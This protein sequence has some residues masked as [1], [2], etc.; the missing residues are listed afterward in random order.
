RE[1][2]DHTVQPSSLVQETFMRLFRGRD[3]GWRDRAHFFA[4]ASLRDA[5]RTG[6]PRARAT[7]QKTWK[8]GGSHSDRSGR[9]SVPG[10]SR[11]GG[12]YRPGTATA[13]GIGPSQEQSSGDAAFWRTEYGRKSGSSGNCIQHSASG[14]ELRSCL[15]PSRVEWR[16]VHAV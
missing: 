7:S 2:K 16:E 9:G 11:R 3:I 14:L 12:C 5:P 6:G 15:A 4:T 1:R 10:P 13:F 8:G